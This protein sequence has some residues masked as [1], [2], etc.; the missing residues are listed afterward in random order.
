MKSR[1]SF[2]KLTPFKKDLTRYAPVW[3]LYLISMLLYV[4]TLSSYGYS[5]HFAARQLPTMIK[6]FGIIN[7]IYGT[8]CAVMLFGDLFNTRMCYALHALPQRRESWLLSHTAAGLCFSIVPN[9][10]LSILLMVKLE[11]YW[12]LGLYWLLAV[13]LQF[14]FFFGLGIFSTLLTANRFAALLVCAGFNFV[15]M[16]IYAAITVLYLPLMVGVSVAISGF[17]RFSPV[18]NLFQFDY[19][20]F[21]AIQIPVPGGETKAGKIET[22]TFF[23]FQNL[24]DGWGY[25][26]ILAVVGIALIGIAL[27]LYRKRHLETAGDFLAF[28]VLKMPAC[29]IITLCV[30]LCTALLGTAFSDAYIIW[31]GLG[32]IVGFFGGLM[33]LERRLK[34]FRKKTFLGFIVIGVCMVLSLVAMDYDWFGIEGWMPKADRVASVTIGNYRSDD[35]L[36]SSS[37]DYQNNRIVVTLENQEDIEKIIDAHE[38][39]LDRLNVPDNSKWHRITI[40]YKMKSGRTVLRSYSAP[41]NGTNYEIFSHYFY[42]PDQIMGY[43]GK[44][45]ADYV[46]SV[47]EIYCNGFPVPTALCEPLLEALRLDCAN[48]GIVT[49]YDGLY[50]VELAI[51]QPDGSNE[52]RVLSVQKSAGNTLAILQSPEVVLQ[53]SDWEDYL[54]GIRRLELDGD[55][56]H[57]DQ[58]QLRKVME[59][60]REDIFLG[61]IT[62]QS[63]SDSRKLLIE[64]TNEYG[65]SEEIMLFMNEK[66][67]KLTVPLLND[68]FTSLDEN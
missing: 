60:I 13:T 43:A 38:D 47:R 6:S 62:T 18:V 7:M 66:E 45:W 63:E 40:Q 24:L 41:A 25:L 12:F 67:C 10:L 61:G 68:Y 28:P 52:W 3:A 53:Y 50:H 22:R 48:K 16:L 33:L 32:L 58:D 37:G 30:C 2:S 65:Y 49:G 8:V 35:L 17:Y 54:S 57:L 26:V 27:W 20:K 44:S 29:I 21:K 55:T 23:E 36:L 56:L 34:V 15:S 31:L 64:Y 14:V 5:D 9:A 42:Q 11:S 4:N 19:F 51:M 46:A 59:A 39:I 1:T